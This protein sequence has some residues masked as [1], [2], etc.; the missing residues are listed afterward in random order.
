MIEDNKI[1]SVSRRIAHLAEVRERV[2]EKEK[3]L[4]STRTDYESVEEKEL[5]MKMV[6]EKKMVNAEEETEF[7]WEKLLEDEEE[8]ATYQEALKLLSQKVRDK[9]NLENIKD[10]N[11][12]KLY[13]D[14]FTV[15][16]MLAFDS[17][18][19]VAQRRFAVQTKN[20]KISSTAR[21]Y[22]DQ[23]VQNEMELKK[24]ARDYKDDILDF[25]NIEK[26]IYMNKIQIMKK[27]DE[28]KGLENDLENANSEFNQG[29]KD[30]HEEL[31]EKGNKQKE[32]S[33]S[34]KEQ[35]QGIEQEMRRLM[36]EIEENEKQKE[37][38]EKKRDIQKLYFEDCDKEIKKMKGELEK[39]G[40]R[41]QIKE[42]MS[43]EAR[44]KVNEE[45]ENP[46]KEGQ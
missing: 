11:V 34:L 27:E 8:K 41:A 38:F 19:Y 39:A 15:E 36:D 29:Y 31:K 37:E 24:I 28:V 46:E 26:T 45:F 30:R 42:G 32:Q 1:E 2:K 7:A 3:I 5:V 40:R 22:V 10:E 4:S 9:N 18:G 20:K 12:K 35:V 23:A 13:M 16:A 6:T 43:D 25:S 33:S 17:L 44:K 21:T 14:C